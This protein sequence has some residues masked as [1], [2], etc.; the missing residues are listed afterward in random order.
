MN[1]KKNSHTHSLESSNKSEEFLTLF[2]KRWSRNNRKVIK[3][4]QNGPNTR[5]INCFLLFLSF[6]KKKRNKTKRR[7]SCAL[8]TSN[9]YGNTISQSVIEIA[10]KPNHFYFLQFVNDSV[11]FVDKSIRALID[12]AFRLTHLNFKKIYEIQIYVRIVE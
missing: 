8:V 11:H 3:N 6:E 5:S 12:D 10:E 9:K 2:L 7:N 4:T 1:K